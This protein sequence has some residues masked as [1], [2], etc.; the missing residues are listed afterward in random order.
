MLKV[1]VGYDVREDIAW[2]VCRHSVARHASAELGVYPLKQ[3][4][5]RELGLYNRSVDSNASTEFSL[6][7]FLTPH[8]AATDGWSVFVDCDFLFTGDITA[9][10]AK[11]D[12]ARAVYVVQHDY[13]P[14]VEIKMD[15]KG[16]TVYPR[17]NWSSMMIFNG[18]HPAVRALTPDIVNSSTPAYLHRLAWIEDDRDIGALDMSW[19]FLVGEYPRPDQTPNAIHYTNGGPWFQNWSDVDYADLWLAERNQLPAEF[20]GDQ[21]GK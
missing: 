6:T 8:L 18:S 17:K 19:N 11:L 5:L 1:Y 14:A 15:G 2:Q 13:V 9:L 7:R 12:P 10:V 4:T 16:Q 21:T 3:A 20:A